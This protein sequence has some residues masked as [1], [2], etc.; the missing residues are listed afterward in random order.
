MIS[1]EDVCKFYQHLDTPGVYDATDP[2][3]LQ[4]FKGKF[5][6]GG[7]EVPG[8]CQRGGMIFK[9]FRAIQ[10]YCFQ[11]YKVV[12]EPRTVMELFKLL[13]LFERL[14]L[15]NNNR[16]KCM[17]EFRPDCSGTYKGYVYCGG[18]EEGNEV[19]AIVKKA[20]SD[21]I[22]PD[23]SIN[24]KRG[25]SEYAAAYPE[26]AVIKPGIEPMKYNEAWRVHEEYFDKHATWKPRASS[27]SGDEERS[28][29]KP[30]EIFAMTVFLRYAA[31]IGDDSYLTIAG[32]VLPPIPGLKRPP[33][34]SPPLPGTGSHTG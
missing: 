27:D 32:G 23:I 17:T 7:E 6:Y 29:Y 9:R 16:R 3:S 5:A 14:H 24:F 21:E 18:L 25:C 11:C 28:T 12:V 1:N 34:V 33:F 4:I 15:P 31:T 22:S 19:C 10:E 26:Y 2:Y 20:V 30:S 13:I 8:I